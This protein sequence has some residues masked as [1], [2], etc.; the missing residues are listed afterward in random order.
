MP[1]AQLHQGIDGAAAHQAKIAD[2][3]RQPDRAAET[4]HQTIESA[5]GGLLQPGLAGPAA[6]LGEGYV[7]S[8]LPGRDELRDD[9]GRVLQ[10]HVDHHDGARAARMIEP[11]GHGRFLA[12]VAAEADDADLRVLRPQAFQYGEAAILRAVV[13]VD[14][15]PGHA[16]PGHDRGQP[17]MEQGN[18]RFF[19]E[20]RNDDRKHGLRAAMPRRLRGIDIGQVA[21][22]VHIRNPS[23]IPDILTD[24]VG[25]AEVAWPRAGRPLAAV[26]HAWDV[27]SLQDKT[28]REKPCGCIAAI[29]LPTILQPIRA[30]WGRDGSVASALGV[31]V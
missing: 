22:V 6:T 13:D 31:R 14:G 9:F 18:N 26:R 17:G 30:A 7:D 4:P 15:L 20:D 29:S 3:G 2:V 1:L 27:H 8:I 12:E 24:G 21:S 19:I 16:D 23:E 25:S 5:G 11:R 28:P 10:I